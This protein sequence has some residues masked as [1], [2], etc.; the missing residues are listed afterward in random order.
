MTTAQSSTLIIGVGNTSRGDDGAGIAVARELQKRVPEVRTIEQSGEGASLMDSWKDAA[1]VF[2]VDA[3]QSGASPG[4]IHR[5]DVHAAP[6]PSHFFHY[7]THAFSV[8][9]AVELA[10]VLNQLPPR[11][12]V[13][14]IEGKDFSAGVGLSIEVERSAAMV[15]GRVLAEILPIN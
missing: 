8:A 15:V 2:L 5:F 9:E 14:G 1:T 10:R 3:T 11:L 4:T 13:Y 6:I 7:S 12:I